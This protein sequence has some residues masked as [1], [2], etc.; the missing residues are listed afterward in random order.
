[1]GMQ[2]GVCVPPYRLK[3]ALGIISIDIKSTRRQKQAQTAM[4]WACFYCAAALTAR[5]IPRL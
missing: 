2:A 5:L 4:V 3:P 1:M